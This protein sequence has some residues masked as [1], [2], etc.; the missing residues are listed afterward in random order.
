VSTET[1]SPFEDSAQKRDSAACQPLLDVATKDLFRNNA[2]RIIGLP[3]DATPREVSKHGDKLKL[4]E[5]LG[6]GDTAGAGAF[7]RK[8]PPTLDEIREALQRLKDPEKRIV[9]E[10]FW[11]W[12]EEFGESQSD[13]SIQALKRGDSK[14][15]ARIWSTKEDHP[16]LGTV[17][18]HNLALAYHIIALDGENRSVDQNIPDD[19]R[20]NITRYW[21]SAFSRWERLVQD[22]RL[23]DKVVSRI[24]QLDEPNLLTGFA[25]RMRASLPQALDK[26]NAE[27]ALAFAENEK[28]DLARVHIQFMRATNR[29]VENFDKIAES[30]LAPT[31]NRLK[32]QIERAQQ[33]AKEVPLDALS[34]ARE[35]LEQARPPLA[36]FD[37]F[38]GKESERRNELSD[39]VAALCN[40]LQVIYHNATGDDEACLG[41]LKEVSP[42][43]VDVELRNTIKDNASKLA[44]FI[45]D[46]RVQAKLKPI[47]ALLKTIGEG[48]EPA[49]ARMARFTRELAP[50]LKNVETAVV[51]GSAVHSELYD[52]AANVLRGISVD[53]WN[54]SNDIA[55]AGAT[56]HLA[57]EYVRTPENKKKLLA[58]ESNFRNISQR[59]AAQK[60]AADKKRRN[61]LIGWG[62][63]FAVLVI[64]GL[65]N[66]QNS[67][68]PT[69]RSTYPPSTPSAVPAQSTFRPPIRSTYPPSTP[70]AVPAQNTFRV[71][72]YIDSEL[73]LE[74][75]AIE[76]EQTQIRRM[77]TQLE[78]L[79]N[80]INAERLALD[81]TDQSAVD[82]FNYKVNDYNTLLEAI[83]ARAREVDRRIDAYNEKLRLNG[84]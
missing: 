12:P 16:E 3:V 63:A 42:L 4:M 75:Q 40:R 45:E 48:K 23:W 62:A 47:Y 28:I 20:Q 67:P 44:G 59:I 24:R 22:D 82:A 58:D 33:R 81:T 74:R 56:I 26:I 78:N 2:F 18:M 65:A 34:A 52:Y 57:L 70:F 13:A 29:G 77:S 53:A 83:K 27:L 76:A 6:H 68:A 10:F 15:A 51:P 49:I 79:G 39:E 69:T 7:S 32:G 36:L 30:T 43:A 1:D 5:K 73:A 35:L 14:A 21:N 38:F 72:S 25:R 54:I 17:A 84:R 50:L 9:D 55:T 71:P 8:P 80:E 11:F 66:S 46:K 64:I 31:R 61:A 41:F 60:E 19:Q 37:L